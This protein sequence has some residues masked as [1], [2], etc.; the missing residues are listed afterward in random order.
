MTRQVLRHGSVA[1][2]SNN[3]QQKRRMSI[4]HDPRSLSQRR[5]SWLL[6]H[7]E[8][9]ARLRPA[10]LDHARSLHRVPHGAKVVAQRIRPDKLVHRTATHWA[11]RSGWQ[12]RQ[13]GH[14]IDCPAE[15]GCKRLALF[16]ARAVAEGS[17]HGQTR[18]TPVVPTKSH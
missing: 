16:N 12:S 15:V 1:R 10:R 4:I 9:D 5:L 7:T 17:T 8:G 2:R 13:E 14:A 6:R 11:H 3:R 18:G